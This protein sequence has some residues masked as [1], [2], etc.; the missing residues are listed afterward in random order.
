MGS[1]DLARRRDDEGTIDRDRTSYTRS[2]ECPLALEGLVE[3]WI[4]QAM[5]P[6][7]ELVGRWRYPIGGGRL[8]KARR[9]G[10]LSE[11]FS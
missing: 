10:K 4:E 5:K 8:V 3:S 9:R 1:N 11:F 6:R 2:V 7:L